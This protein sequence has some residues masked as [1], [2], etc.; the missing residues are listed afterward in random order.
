[1]NFP[2]RNKSNRF[3][4][5]QA[6]FVLNSGVIVN[7]DYRFPTVEITDCA[8][9]YYLQGNDA[10]VFAA[11]VKGICKRFPSIAEDVAELIVSYDYL[12]VMIESI[13]V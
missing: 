5:D 3:L 1:M 9:S 12:G 11:K 10:E 4:L 8:S 13:E 2:K 7:S 6:V